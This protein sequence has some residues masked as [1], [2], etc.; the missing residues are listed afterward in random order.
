MVMKFFNRNESDNDDEGYTE[1]QQL[2]EG[3]T[4]SCQQ[5]PIVFVLLQKLINDFAVCKDCSETLLLVE[6]ISH[7]F[8]NKTTYFKKKPHFL[9]DQPSSGGSN[10]SDF[11]GSEQ[12][13]VPYHL[14][15]F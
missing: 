2:L 4:N 11:M 13:F 12:K 5:L 15:V 10:V 3:F 14:V 9:L 1:Q 7:G 8:G 6:D